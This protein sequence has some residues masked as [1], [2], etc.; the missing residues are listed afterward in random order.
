MQFLVASL[1]NNFHLFAAVRMPNRIVVG[2]PF[3]ALNG[4]AAMRTI[5]LLLF[6]WLRSL[7]FV[8]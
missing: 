3:F 6:G 4:F 5:P 2:F 8:C 7:L 1:M